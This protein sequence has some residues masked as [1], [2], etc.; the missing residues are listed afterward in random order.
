LVDLGVDRRIN[1]KKGR[2]CDVFSIH[3]RKTYIQS[4]G[5]APHIINLGNGWRLV[6]KFMA[7]PLSAVK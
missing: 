5:I 3:T 4:R 2:K 7:Q 1:L 6:I